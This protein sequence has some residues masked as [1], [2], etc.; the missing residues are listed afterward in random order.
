D[1][2]IVPDLP[3]EEALELKTIAL[4][5]NIALI[6]LVTP[7]SKHRIKKLVSNATGF[8]YLV[9]SKGITGKRDEFDEQLQATIVEIKK[10]TKTPIA[11]GFGISNATQVKKLALNSDGII[12]GSAI[13]E[14]IQEN[15]NDLKELATFTKEIAQAL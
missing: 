10:H 13:V 12:I 9:S 6:T 4:E 15:P 8:I 7:N 14:I 11:I 5:Y 2:L 1:G 3:Y